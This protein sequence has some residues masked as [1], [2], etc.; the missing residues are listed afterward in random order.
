M[1]KI[2]DKDWLEKVKLGSRVYNEQ[3]LCRDFQA[4]EVDRFVQWLFEQYGV[5]YNKGD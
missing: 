3:R 2:N 4:Q 5:I 1:H